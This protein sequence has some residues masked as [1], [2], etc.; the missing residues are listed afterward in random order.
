MTS[1]TT[2]PGFFVGGAQDLRSWRGCVHVPSYFILLLNRARVPPPQARRYLTRR[3][4]IPPRSAP[5][6][7]AYDV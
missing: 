2:E 4:Y 7:V 1:S 6:R 5:V 3:P